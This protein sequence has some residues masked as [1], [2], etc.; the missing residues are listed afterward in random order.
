MVPAAPTTSTA[1]PLFNCK[2]NAFVAVNLDVP[3]VPTDKVPD[4]I[5][6]AKVEFQVT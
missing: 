2:G 3:D 4:V 1:K 5:V 6:P